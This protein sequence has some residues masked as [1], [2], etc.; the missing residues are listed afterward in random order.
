MAAD[1]VP[2][3]FTHA[4]NTPSD[5]RFIDVP[6]V[7]APAACRIHFQLYRPPPAA[8]ADE[9][10][11]P[12]RS[13]RAIVLVHGGG[14]HSRWWDWTAPFLAADGYVVASIDLSGQ[15]ESGR[16]EVYSMADNA[17][18]V[19]AVAE[20]LQ[21]TGESRG[22][23]FLVGHS[24]GGWVVLLCAR[25]HGERLGGAVTLDSAVRPPGARSSESVRRI[26]S[27]SR[28]VPINL[29]VSWQS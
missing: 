4:V 17:A 8:A 6:G 29:N 3:W 9:N 19:M 13:P 18:E 26:R 11:G 24:Y 15:G 2:A 10:S 27:L 25:D 1:A 12:P 22:R 5:D 28:N 16:R 23:P 14:A 20:H 21:A 7:S